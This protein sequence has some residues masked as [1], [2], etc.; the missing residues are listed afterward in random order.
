M[1]V[2]GRLGGL[3]S[4]GRVLRGLGFRVGNEGFRV[5]GL[6]IGGLEVWGVRDSGGLGV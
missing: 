1:K 2:R 5:K 4:A 6:A 3:G